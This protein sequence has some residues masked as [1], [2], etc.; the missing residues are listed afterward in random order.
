LD[1]IPP[2]EEYYQYEDDR[3]WEVFLTWLAGT[4]YTCCIVYPEDDIPKNEYLIAS[5]KSPRGFS[6]A[7]IW[8]NG[9][10][11]HDPHP[12]QDGLVGEPSYYIQF[13]KETNL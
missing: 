7:V 1:D 2:I 12:S 5:G 6:H 11:V 9:V 4:G 8:K 10:M 3:Y 13:V